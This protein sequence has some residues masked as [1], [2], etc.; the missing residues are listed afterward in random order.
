MAIVTHWLEQSRF[1]AGFLDLSLKS[2]VILLAAGGV[3]LCWRRAAACTRHLV[4]VLA[5]GGLLCLP[6][7]SGLVPASQRPVWTVATRAES[8]NELTLTLEF[9]PSR[10]GPASLRPAAARPTTAGI[11]ARASADRPGRQPLA[12]RFRIAWAAA[13]LLA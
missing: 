10:A 4:W 6:V 2:T 12:A 7:L 11:P 13:A 8:P 5:V 3:C 9:L 1:V